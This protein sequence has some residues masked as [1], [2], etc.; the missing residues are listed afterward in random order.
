MRPD[1]SGEGPVGIEGRDSPGGGASPV[2]PTRSS[3][4]AKRSSLFLDSARITASTNA[5][6]TPSASAD[7]GAGV[8]SSTD[9]S[10]DTLPLAVLHGTLPV[11]S[12]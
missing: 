1:A 10:S 6:G 8:P 2:A 4:D 9:S 12:S 7:S 11:R 5:G 3:I